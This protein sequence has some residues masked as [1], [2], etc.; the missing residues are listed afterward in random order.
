ME[1]RRVAGAERYAIAAQGEPVPAPVLRWQHEVHGDWAYDLELD[2]SR[3]SP[4]ECAS[5]IAEHLRGSPPTAF[6]G[7]AR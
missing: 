6:A 2:T 4:S 3:L 1:R 7:L 5:T